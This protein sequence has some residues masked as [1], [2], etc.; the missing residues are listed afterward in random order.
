MTISG[1]ALAAGHVHI[2]LGDLVQILAADEAQALHQGGVGLGLGLGSGHA[3]NGDAEQLGLI[4]VVGI[5]GSGAAG[6]EDQLALI[7]HQVVAGAP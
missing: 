2:L 7:V 3:H 5:D 1:I 6:G 4:G